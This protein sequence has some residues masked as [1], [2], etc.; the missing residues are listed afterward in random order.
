[1][2]WNIDKRAIKT[3]TETQAEQKGVGK[4]G[5]RDESVGFVGR[6]RNIS[7]KYT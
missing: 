3:D 7:V 6:R 2:E 1:M 4:L 5:W